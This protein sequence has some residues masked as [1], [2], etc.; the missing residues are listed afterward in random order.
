MYMLNDDING[1]RTYGNKKE[2]KAAAEFTCQTEMIPVTLFD[3]Q[4]DE[5]IWPIIGRI[6]WRSDKEAI[7]I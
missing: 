1:Q 6:E 3:V 2:A 7:V 5:T 4:P